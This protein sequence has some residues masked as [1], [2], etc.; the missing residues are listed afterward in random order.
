MAPRYG[1]PLWTGKALEMLCPLGEG[2]SLGLQIVLWASL[3][4]KEHFLQHNPFDWRPLMWRIWGFCVQLPK[5]EIQRVANNQ[6]T[7]HP[8]GNFSKCFWSVIR[9]S[10]TPESVVLILQHSRGRE[11][12]YWENQPKTPFFNGISVDFDQ[13]NTSRIPNFAKKMDTESYSQIGGKKFRTRFCGHLFSRQ[14]QNG[15]YFL[16]GKGFP[17][18]WGRLERLKSQVELVLIQCC[19]VLAPDS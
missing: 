10:L 1:N 3:D 4:G 19:F 11:S 12:L 13:T 16:F 14:S 18:T 9:C 17:T 5:K 7:R 6:R 8:T 2:A 15:A